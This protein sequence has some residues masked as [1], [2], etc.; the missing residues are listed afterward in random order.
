MIIIQDGTRS[1]EARARVEDRNNL[2]AKNK[3]YIGTGASSTVN[4]HTVWETEGKNIIEAINDAGVVANAT[5][6][7]SA[8]NAD[9]A[10]NAGNATTADQA[11]NL[12]S[13]GK[14]GNYNTNEIIN[15]ENGFVRNANYANNAGLATNA[16][17]ATY[18]Q[19]SGTVI[20]IVAGQTEITEDELSKLETDNCIIKYQPDLDQQVYVYLEKSLFHDGDS[21]T[22]T[23]VNS[24]DFYVIS[25]AI[26]KTS[27]IVPYL[28]I[29][30]SKFSVFTRDLYRWDLVGRKEQNSGFLWLTTYS[31]EDSYDIAP[32]DNLQEALKKIFG[33]SFEVAANGWLVTSSSSGT[34]TI[35]SITQ[36]S[37]RYVAQSINGGQNGE[38]DNS[39]KVSS[40]T[41]TNLTKK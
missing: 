14:I 25:I 20:S 29:S 8:T 21:I 7:V 23:G 41:K 24:S 37:Y 27:S 18:A 4:G 35:L 10:T 26:S 6:A 28:S 19:T 16:Q 30:I 36:D 9:Y 3:I 31:S 12:T 34:Y 11:T 15:F 1:D 17:N 39:W 22:Y 2:D 32:N 38:W 5:N 40:F 13:T 33:E